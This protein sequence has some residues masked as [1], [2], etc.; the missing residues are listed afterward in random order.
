LHRCFAYPIN[1]TKS[2]DAN[3]SGPN[4]SEVTEPSHNGM[5]KVGCITEAFQEVGHQASAALIVEMVRK[6]HQH[7]V[8]LKLVESIR[9]LLIQ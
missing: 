2:V 1:T 9:E 5:S 7:D 4:M 3:L 8:D 6:R